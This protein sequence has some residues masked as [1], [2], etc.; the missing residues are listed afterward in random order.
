M[1]FS[2][3]PTIRAAEIAKQVR[4]WHE[5]HRES[6]S[7]RWFRDPAAKDHFIHD[8]VTEVLRVNALANPPDPPPP[9][10]VPPPPIPMA[11]FSKKRHR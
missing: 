5:E 2:S 8:L 6:M 10:P 9:A 7:E 1:Q 11:P 3:N 4:A